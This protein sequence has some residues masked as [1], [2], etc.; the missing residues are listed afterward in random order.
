MSSYFPM[1]DFKATVCASTCDNRHS[2][3]VPD[4]VDGYEVKTLSLCYYNL[5]LPL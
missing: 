2:C 4:A 3:A 1:T 5:V